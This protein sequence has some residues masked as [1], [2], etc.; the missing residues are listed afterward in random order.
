[1]TAAIVE[2]AEPVL[3][4]DHD[5]E[6]SDAQGKTLGELAGRLERVEAAVIANRDLLV[7]IGKKLSYLMAHPWES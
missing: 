7:E 4:V 3:T 1:M 2:P 5:V 6:E